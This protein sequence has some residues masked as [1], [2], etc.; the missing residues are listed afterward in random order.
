[1]GKKGS[2]SLARFAL[3]PKDC[4]ENRK[5]FKVR[6]D[7]LQRLQELQ[8]KLAEVVLEEAD[9]DE[10]P[11]AGKP[12]ADLTQ[13][14]RGDRYWSKKNAAATF[15]LLER[16]TSTLSY[17]PPTALAPEAQEADIDKQI[18]KREREAGVLLDTVLKKAR[19]AAFD[20]RAVGKK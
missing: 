19:K 13:Q 20:D 11:G 3:K 2:A 4:N 14:E 8:E 1:M 12:L 9:P 15:A 16:T 17:N 5:G 6:P 7:Q 18:A 10:W